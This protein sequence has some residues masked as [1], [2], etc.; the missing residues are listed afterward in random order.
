MGQILKLVGVG[1]LDGSA[2]EDQ[3]NAYKSEEQRSWTLWAWF[4]T[5]AGHESTL[6]TGSNG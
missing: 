1:D 4:Q 3:R 6:K 5:R 2:D